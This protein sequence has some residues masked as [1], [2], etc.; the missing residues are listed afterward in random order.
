MVAWTAPGT[1]VSVIEQTETSL[2]LQVDR[3]G[4]DGR[5]VLSRLDY[6]G[7]SISGA[8]YKLNPF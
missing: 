5:V 7:Y 2:E 6:P 1:A 3:V 8:A 4:E